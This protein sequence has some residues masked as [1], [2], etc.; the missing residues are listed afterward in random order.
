MGKAFLEMDENYREKI[1]TDIN[2]YSN[3]IDKLFEDD[4]D[5]AEVAKEY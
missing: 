4:T 1:L 5:A 3:F 2:A